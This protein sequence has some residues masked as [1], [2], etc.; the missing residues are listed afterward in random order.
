MKLVTCHLATSNGATNAGWGC[1]TN[2]GWCCA[3]NAGW[4][5]ATK[6]ILEPW[7]TQWR[8]ECASLR[9]SKWRPK[10]HPERL[11]VTYLPLQ[12][13]AEITIRNTFR[14]RA[15]HCRNTPRLPIETSIFLPQYWHVGVLA[16]A[17]ARQHF[18]QD[19]DL[20]PSWQ[21]G[22]LY[23]ATHVKLM[24]IDKNMDDCWDEMGWA[25][26]LQ[27]ACFELKN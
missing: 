17:L 1:A 21:H 13:H 12:K 24:H 7:S 15:C 25:G 4:C 2:A 11:S 23:R 5:C 9:H 19:F 6:R 27:G 22:K 14:W 3:T 10:H 8:Y 16:I 20:W 26:R 18:L